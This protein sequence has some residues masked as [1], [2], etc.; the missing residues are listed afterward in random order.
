MNPSL[1][2]TSRIARVGV[3]AQALFALNVLVS[4]LLA[5][6]YSFLNNDTSDL[7][8]KTSPN[9]LP[10]N[11]A[12]SLSGL[13]TVGVAIAL[14]RT[15]DRSRLQTVGVA[16]IGVFAV[17]QFIDGIAREDCPVSVDAVCRAAE[18]AGQVS[19]MHMAHN[20]ESLFTFS[21]LMAAPLVLAF[22]FRRSEQYKGLFVPSLLCGV[23]QLVCLPVFLVMYDRGAA[24][25]GAVEI[26]EF[27]AGIM[28][29]ALAAHRAAVIAG[30]YASR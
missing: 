29:L 11:I 28:W 27:V 21:A 13:L 16:L 19:G 22:A 23:V 30:Q 15:L 10:Y 7:G 2:G 14:W 5:P 6:G 1:S 24:G 4:G 17:G 8:A 12:L 25:Q 18:K 3:A 9:A 26:L 20:I